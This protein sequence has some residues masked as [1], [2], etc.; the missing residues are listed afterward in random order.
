MTPAKG[1]I[2]RVTRPLCE[3]FTGHRWIPLT[4][5]SDAEL[6]LFA[7]DMRRHHTQYDVNVMEI[8][9]NLHPCVLSFVKSIYLWRL[10]M[11]IIIEYANVFDV[12]SS[13][14]HTLRVK[15]I[16]LYKLL[17]SQIGIGIGGV[18]E[19][20]ASQ[21]ECQASAV[22]VW[23]VILSCMLNLIVLPMCCFNG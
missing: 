22:I 2:F 15:S 20:T 8:D 4:K 9:V 21:N 13:K 18:L 1:T 23:K 5:A 19:T 12:S 6:W 17:W 3:E 16:H 7:G 10:L 14:S 11:F